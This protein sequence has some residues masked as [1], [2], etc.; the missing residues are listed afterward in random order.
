LKIEKIHR[1]Q[2]FGAVLLRHFRANPAPDDAGWS[3]VLPRD[4]I[5]EYAHHTASD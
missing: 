3:A 2:V 4:V 1:P 5:V